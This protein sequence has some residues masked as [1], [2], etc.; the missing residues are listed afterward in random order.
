V[1]RYFYQAINTLRILFTAPSTEG[2]RKH[3]RQSTIET[4]APCVSAAESRACCDDHRSGFSEVCPTCL[5]EPRGNT[6]RNIVRIRGTNRAPRAAR[7]SPFDTVTIVFHWV[8]VLIVLAM[9]ATAWWHAS[10]HPGVLRSSLLQ[11]HRSLG[12]TIWLV[13]ALR[14]VWRLTRAKLPPFPGQMSKMHRAVVKASEYS[15]YGLLLIQP[16]TGF[17]ATLSKGRSFAIF[18]WQFPSLVPE[19]ATLEAAFYHAHQ[20]GACALGAL[21]VGHAGA[22]LIHHFFLRD[23]VLECMAPMLKSGRPKKDSALVDALHRPSFAGDR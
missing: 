9:F 10:V 12:V 11:L 6:D 14:L 16:L 1:G 23:D 5:L 22:A 20:L 15:L 18:L 19:H 7:R 21:I 2:S 13:T 4:T 8:T 17:A 3:D